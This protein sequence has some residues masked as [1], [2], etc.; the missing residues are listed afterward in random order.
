M[1]DKNLDH[2][3]QPICK[4]AVQA[5][6]IINKYYTINKEISFKADKSPLTEADL[7]SNK[8]SSNTRRLLHLFYIF[9]L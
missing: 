4:I 3:L 2:L 9:W 5:G 7:E 8:F 6:L 1:N